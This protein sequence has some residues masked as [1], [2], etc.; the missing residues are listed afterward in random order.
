[1]FAVVRV[2]GSVKV[3]K[4]INDTL[5]MLRLN[6]VNH[7]VI[8]PDKPQ[9][10]G[11]FK[12]VQGYITWGEVDKKVL[13][14]LLEKRGRLVGNKPI[15][16]KTLKKLGFANFE[17]LADALIKGKADMG[18]LKAIKPVFRLN[19]PRKGFKATRLPFPKGDLGYRK[20]KINDLLER[21]I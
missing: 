19:P 16:S 6:R 7:C 15:D 8:L 12:I 18:K 21:M 9:Y 4:E 11:M 5:S 10:V 3:K 2:R 13:T 20:K 14:K 17:K 1:L